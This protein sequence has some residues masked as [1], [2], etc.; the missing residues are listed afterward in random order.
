MLKNL[1]KY[2]LLIFILAIFLRLFGINHGYPFIFHPDESTVV[3][4]ALG[5]RFNFNPGHFDWPHLYI[6]ANY[7][8]YMVFSYVRNMLPAS[9]FPIIWDD[10]WIFYLLTRCFTALLGALTVFPIYFASKNLFNKNVGIFSALTIAIVPFHVWHSHY[11]LIDVPMVFLLSIGLYF[12]SRIYLTN[13][14]FDYVFS[15]VFIGLAASTKYHGGLS[16]IMVP[17]ATLLYKFKDLSLKQ[18]RTIKKFLTYKDLKLWII[19]GIFALIGFLVGTPYALLDYATF[20]RTDNSN[21]ALW[22]FTNVGSL[23]FFNHIGSFFEVL[24]TKLPDDLGYTILV[25]FILVLFAFFYTAKFLYL[26]S[27]TSSKTKSIESKKSFWN[28][29]ISDIYPLSFIVFMSLFLLW[30]ISGF[31]KSR[32]HYHLL[33]YPFISI[34]FG[35]FLYMITNIKGIFFKRLLFLL[36]IG[37]PLLTSFKDSYIF[38][39]GDT[40]RDLYQWLYLKDNLPPVVYDLKDLRDVFSKTTYIKSNKGFDNVYRYDA[41]YVIITEEDLFR[42]TDYKLELIKEF[43][44]KLKR[45]PVI[46]IYRFKK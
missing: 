29:P 23:T 16:A 19:S 8:L 34:A 6:Y 22:Q 12:I 31:E 33:S 13:K 4:S 7:F 45:G 26:E 9:S 37:I 15:G 35:Y 36:L 28:L 27:G 24:F 5:L 30:Y 17:L 1:N 3:R 21:G 46:S 25:G 41:G 43:D 40:R 18:L 10:T 11:S 39:H 38:S 2:I 44:N 42:N 14:L 20:S 32:S